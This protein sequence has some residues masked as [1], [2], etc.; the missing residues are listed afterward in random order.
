MKGRER[1]PDWEEA[2]QTLRDQFL[3]GAPERFG[4]IETALGRL[5]NDCSDTDALCSLRAEFHALSGLGGTYGFPQVTRLGTEGETQ[6][7]G[8]LTAGS[9]PSAADIAAWKLLLDGLR[10]GVGRETP[11][12]AVESQTLSAAPRVLLVSN[13]REEEA[14]LRL[15]LESAGYDLRTVSPAD[16]WE[17]ETNT[18]SPD[19]ILI[20]SS[21]AGPRPNGLPDSP[22][23]AHRPDGPP[24][25]V[26]AGEDEHA[27]YVAAGVD[28]L[29]KPVPPGLL[30]FRVAS[31]IERARAKSPS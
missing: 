1:V 10:A 12:R 8:R 13:D 29:V 28:H 5:E 26:L 21:A 22:V 20:A 14:F 19:L 17:R 30:L 4:R 31:R 27:G 24:I 11:D 3:R 16:R 25:L 6:C 9:R 15:V 23:R 18:F 2:L 7:D